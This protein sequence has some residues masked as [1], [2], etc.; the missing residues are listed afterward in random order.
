M[1]AVCI[2]FARTVRARALARFW[3]RARPDRFK[4]LEPSAKAFQMQRKNWKQWTFLAGWY[5]AYLLALEFWRFKFGIFTLGGLFAVAGV[6]GWIIFFDRRQN[7]Q[8][9]ASPP[10][11]PPANHEH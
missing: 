8:P 5:V 9:P 7:P 6:W 2:D 1:V 4:L 3:L 10:D 11:G